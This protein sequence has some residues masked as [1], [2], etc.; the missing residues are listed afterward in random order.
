MSDTR[1]DGA[2]GGTARDPEVS[3]AAVPAAPDEL[4]RVARLFEMTN[5]LLA[6]LSVDGCFTLVNPAWERALGWTR[7]ELLSRP[8][9]EFVHADDVD[10][11][12]V[13][14][15]S[16]SQRQAE[17][18]NFTSRFRH[19]DGE[20][21]TLAWS[22]RCDGEVW[23]L[24]ARDVTERQSLERRALQALHDPLTKLP[25]RLLLMDRTRQALARLQ[26]S[27]GLIALIFIDLDKF[28]IVN[29]RYGH[30]VGDEVLMAVSER[31]GELM[32]DSDT[33]A[34]LGGDEFV[35]LA[36]ELESEAEALALAERVLGALQRTIRVGR[37]NVS[38]PAS[39]GISI[40]ADHTADPEAMLREADVAMY[41]AK[42]AG[43]HRLELFGESL[44]AEA[45]AQLEIEERLLHA[46][47]RR[48]LRLTYQPIVPLAGGRA[49]GCEALLRWHPGDREG[50]TIEEL[51]PAEFLPR[52]SESELIVQIGEWVLHAACAQAA[53]WRRSGI[54]IPVSVNVSERELV[55]LDIAERVSAALAKFRLPGP[56]LCIEVSEQAVV[57][58]LERAKEALTSV[59]RLGV[60]TA[61]D[62]FGMLEPSLNLTRNLPLDMLKLDRELIETFERDRKTRAMVAGTIALA[63]EAGLKAVAVGIETQ[64]QLAL[65]RELGCTV[66]QGFL[67]HRPDLPSRVRL[68]SGLADVTSAPWRPRVQLGQ[69]DRRR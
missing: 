13:C 42:G 9:V 26:R 65:A 52:A 62:N 58:D 56:A 35:I 54:A 53:T 19:R 28:K 38:M 33:V 47:P 63:K 3:L 34:R 4:A 40:A 55:D 30:D 29:D 27:D 21:R 41:R 60:I 31:L 49:I 1:A 32:R 8:L 20:W 16:G 23:F 64:K 6:T 14:M 44:R 68:T 15:L 66:G 43:G 12:L 10:Q 2:R 45:S 24:A 69:R 59:R 39:V 17:L 18:E 5:E 48:E 51:L 22:G 36:E 46:L 67:L 50:A 7:A 61:L 25:N 37:T 11:T 57:H